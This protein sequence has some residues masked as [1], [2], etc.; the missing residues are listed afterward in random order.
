[1]VKWNEHRQ[2]E[3]VARLVATLFFLEALSNAFN[4]PSL[5]AYWLCLDLQF[6]F[7]LD[8]WWDLC[9]IVPCSCMGLSEN[10]LEEWAQETLYFGQV[11]NILWMRKKNWDMYRWWKGSK[12]WNYLPC[13][14]G[15]PNCQLLSTFT[16]SSKNI[17]FQWHNRFFWVQVALKFERTELRI[18]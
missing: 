11:I 3:S 2:V 4:G 14:S 9:M 15:V 10:F 7:V 8:S 1:M 13:C 6:P 18:L 12:A 16:S 5:V 17:I